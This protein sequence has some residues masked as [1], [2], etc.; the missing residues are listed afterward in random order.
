MSRGCPVGE[1][2][3]KAILAALKTG[4]TTRQVAEEFK[5]APSTISEVAKRNH[6]DITE[7]VRMKKADIARTCYAAEDRIKLIGRGLDKV[8]TLLKSCDNAR[9]LQALA[10]ASAIW[11]D[12]RRLEES[13]D[14]TARGGEIRA[15]FEKMEGE[16]P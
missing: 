6:F 11:I 9:D 12:K 4:K 16:G 10:M 1:E 2:E 8:A 3:E 14:P 7:R 5:R 13:T 15:L